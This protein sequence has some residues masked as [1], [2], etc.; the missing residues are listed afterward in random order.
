[1]ADRER[2]QRTATSEQT[3]SQTAPRR[4][5][6]MPKGLAQ[7]LLA[8][9]ILS[10]AGWIVYGRSL[11]YPFLFDDFHTVLM[12]PSITKLWPLLGESSP[13]VAPFDS[14]TAGRP[15][16]NL[17][18]AINYHFGQFDT[19]GY[20]IFNLVLH[21]LSALILW[22]LLQRTL[23]LPYF[24]NRFD[25]GAFSISLLVALAWLVHPLQTEAVE[26]TT[27]RTE[28]M[29]G[30][31]YLATLYGSLR[32]FTATTLIARTA[33]LAVAGGSCLLGVTCKEVMVTAPVVVLLFERT[34]VAGSFLQ[35]LR[36][37]WPLYLLLALSWGALLVLNLSG[38]RSDSAGFKLGVAAHEWWFTQ[39]K[40]LAMY[41]KLV[42]WPWP[43]S[44][45]Y[46]VPLLTTYAEA[47]PWLGLVGLLGIGAIVLVWRGSAVGFL[48]ACVFLIL[49]PTLAVPIIK[50]VAVERR[51]YLALA[52][53]LT[54]VIVGAYR[55][56]QTVARTQATASTEPGSERWPLAVTITICAILAVAM[57]A[58]SSIRLTAYQDVVTIWQDAAT[59]DPDDVIAQHNVGVALNDAHR[60]AEAVEYM[61]HV[62]E[63]DPDSPEA[64]HVLGAALL[65]LNQPADAVF[66]LKQALTGPDATL[67]H[68]HL[69]MA[70][71]SIGKPDEAIEHFKVIVKEKPNVAEYQNRLGMAMTMAGQPHS[72]IEHFKIA[73]DLAP[74]SPIIR[75]NLG[76]AYKDAGRF[77][78]AC[79]ELEDVVRVAPDFADARVQL[80]I[81]YAGMGRSAD[82]IATAERA[83][84][85]ARAEQNF[86]LAQFLEN[87][88]K[89]RRK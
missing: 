17:S 64:N 69:G 55:L 72:A 12:N 29:M 11:R 41:L 4:G 75:A 24:A 37:S 56:L 63:R 89:E 28:L 67:A 52:A 13:L 6:G 59:R 68:L 51:M 62:V 58:V 40:V 5:L 39:A 34:F 22:A 36:R 48:G 16:V 9:I 26:Y 47:W 14:P 45:H 46:H 23:Q 71:A 81:V 80:A 53:I 20:H 61:R 31:F 50:E 78:E 8:L 57:S 15:L 70:L 33:W 73:V 27:Q 84:E 87:W 88:L 83:L 43:L 60:S 82:A 2:R 42:F 25:R 7:G 76:C 49:S 10:V 65:N 77:P 21:V 44:I 32:Y 66:Y 35:A 18:L 74:D 54:L 30:F 38:P 86:G 19:F 1:M 85:M 79:K 3:A